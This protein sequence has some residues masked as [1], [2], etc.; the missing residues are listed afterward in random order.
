VVID[1]NRVYNMPCAY[2]EFAICPVAPAQNTLPF[3]LEA[4]EQLPNFAH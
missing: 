2:T 3:L 4:G 1:L